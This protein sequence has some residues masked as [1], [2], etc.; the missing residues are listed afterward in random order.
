MCG[1][2]GVCIYKLLVSIVEGD[3]KAPFSLATTSRWRGGC[4]SFPGLL[5]FTLDP[6]LIML[7][8]KQG[9]I[10]YFFLSLWYDSTWDWSPFSWAIGKHST[11]S[12]LFHY[13]LTFFFFCQGLKKF[14]DSVS[15]PSTPFQF[16][17]NLLL[18]LIQ[19]FSF[20]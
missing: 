3:P 19:T 4:H 9:D 14:F 12:F 6:Y 16:L 11:H 5:H 18:V 2:V 17:F 13:N 7:C 8:V 15:K 1:W 10:K 20:L